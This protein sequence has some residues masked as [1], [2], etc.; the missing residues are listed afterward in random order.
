MRVTLLDNFP[1]IPANRSRC[2]C[3]SSLP[4]A[5]TERRT[6]EIGARTGTNA[7]WLAEHGFDVLGVDLAPLAVE[8]ARGKMQGRELRCRFATVDFLATPPPNGPFHFIFDRGCFHV[9]DEPEERA[10][11]GAQVAATLAPSGLWLSLIGSTEGPPR[12]VGSPRR[13]AREVAAAI[14]PRSKSSSCAQPSS[15][16]TVQRV[17]LPLA[18]AHHP[19]TT[20]HAP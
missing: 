12:Q 7:I 9:F 1:G 20:L 3:T 15:A 2:W 14:E 5:F 8:R 4:L 11:F 16:V 17:V 13:S 6:L 18:P 19:G 10:R